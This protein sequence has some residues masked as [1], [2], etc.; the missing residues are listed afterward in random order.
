MARLT[1][2]LHSDD[3]RGSIKGGVTYSGWRG[4]AYARATVTPR[5]PKSAKQLGVR[6]MMSFLAASWAAIKVASAASWQGLADAGIFSTYNAYVQHNLNRWQNFL[7]PTASYPAAGSSTPNTVTTQTPTGGAGQVNISLEW[8]TNADDWGVA[9]L[10]D[11]SAITTPDWTKV[12]DVV[13][14]TSAGKLTYVDSPLTAGTY[15]YRTVI[16]NKDGVM[17][18]VHADSD[19]VTVS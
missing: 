1:G 15:Y 19:A 10:R 3:A 18:T 7:A 16:L 4:R 2:P 6:G 14:P 12:I 5:N 17:G 9:I 11:T 13:A 8:S